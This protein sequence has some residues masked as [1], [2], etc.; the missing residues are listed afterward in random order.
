MHVI[1]EHPQSPLS[2]IIERT[3]GTFWEHLGCRAVAVESGRTVIALDVEP[4]HLNPM[5]IVHGGVLSSLLDSAMGVAVMHAHPNHHAVTTNLNLHFVASFQ[6][7]TLTA[8][9]HIIHASR[10]TVTVEARVEDAQG[11]LGTTATGSFR[12]LPK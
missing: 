3:P 1:P 8:T 10:S 11:K 12:L 9:A 6:E 5:G 2:A 7:G 4:K